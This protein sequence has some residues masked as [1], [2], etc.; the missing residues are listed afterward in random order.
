MSQQWTISK[1]ASLLTV[2]IE[3]SDI[4]ATWRASVVDAGSHRV[5]G[6]GRSDDRFEDVVNISKANLNVDVKLKF[7]LQ[8]GLFGPS[9][10]KSYKVKIKWLEDG[11]ETMDST[12]FGG[13][14][15]PD[16]FDFHSVTVKIVKN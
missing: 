15:E 9:V 4:R 8:F 1:D 2:A 11:C 10:K 7:H 16:G 14:T 12:V 6:E 13:E 5:L 3:F